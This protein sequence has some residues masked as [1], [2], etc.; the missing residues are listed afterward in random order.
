MSQPSDVAY[1]PACSKAPPKVRKQK[2]V[3]PVQTEK[4][5]EPVAEKEE[6]APAENG[7]PKAEEVEKNAFFSGN[8]LP[9]TKFIRFFSDLCA[10]E[11]ILIYIY[12]ICIFI[13][14]EQGLLTHFIF[15]IY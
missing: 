11:L 15:L 6:E 10:S 9:K 4:K 14:G 7:E 5:E 1:Y 2:Q 13:K 12:R 8:I 3:K